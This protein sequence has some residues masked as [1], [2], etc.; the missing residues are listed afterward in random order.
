MKSIYPPKI[1]R[2]AWLEGIRFW[3][4]LIILLY[5]Y[6]LLFSD[7]AFAPQGTGLLENWD[8]ILRGSALFGQHP[9]GYGLSLVGWFGYQWVDWFVLVSGFSLVLSLKGKPLVVGTFLRDRLWRILL[10]FWTTALL[11]Y[12]VLWTIGA[13]TNTYRPDAWHSFAG[14][15]F[16]LLF[17]FG[18][19]LLLST[20]GPWW[21]VPLIVSFA[22]VFP[23]LWKLA[24]RWG[25]KRLLGVAIALTLAYR[26]LAVYILGGHPTYAIQAAAAGWQPFV[27]FIAKLGTFVAGMAVAVAYTQGRGVLF[28][29]G[30]RAIAWGL[31]IYTLGFVCQFY[32]WGWIISDTLIALGLGLITMAACRPLAKMGFL[33]RTMT[34]LGK[35][36]YSYF[37]V[38]NFVI[39]R[40]IRLWVKQDINLYYWGLFLSV[41]TTFGLALVIDRVTPLVEQG[42]VTIWRWIDRRLTKPTIRT[43]MPMEE[44]LVLY[45]GQWGWQIAQVEKVEHSDRTL[46]L[47][48]ISRMGRT[49]WVNQQDLVLDE[50]RDRTLVKS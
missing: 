23:L 37:L 21:F 22:V 20:S 39:D 38:H 4:A 31:P 44:D 24:G 28:W 5:H 7:Y 49:L 12:P 25:I 34:Y 15:T 26:F 9:G 27:P 50:D 1:Q 11:A 48:R 17:D 30:Q 33:S 2:L 40:L 6:Q 3:A 19:R 35:H 46:Y 14:L 43:W 36:S 18:G 45:Q 13:L 41:V 16:P 47:C 42:L 29:S 8:R 32:N 10:P